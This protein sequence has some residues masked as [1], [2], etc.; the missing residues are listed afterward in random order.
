MNKRLPDNFPAYLMNH[1]GA[2]KPATKTQIE[3]S[4]G[5]GR[6]GIFDTHPSDGDRIRKARRADE[7]GVFD[8]DAPATLLFSNFEVLAKQVT[9]LHYSDDL[10]IP[11]GM[12]RLSPVEAP[13]PAN[14][15]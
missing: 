14:A 4:A 6:T 7:P 2:L 15:V 13:K 8:L 12:A 9:Q 10:G 1:D 5:L 11:M 3:D